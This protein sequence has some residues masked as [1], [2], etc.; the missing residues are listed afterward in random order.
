MK[1]TRD[2]FQK[3]IRDT[4]F[5]LHEAIKIHMKTSRGNN[6]DFDIKFIWRYGVG[7]LEEDK[8]DHCTWCSVYNNTIITM[9]DGTKIVS[10]DDVGGFVKDVFNWFKRR[11]LKLVMTDE[12]EFM[13][14]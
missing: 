5:E 4:V 9:P 11:E 12:V 6:Y 1:L 7:F 2:H 13:D 14:I 8:E 10:R 3:F